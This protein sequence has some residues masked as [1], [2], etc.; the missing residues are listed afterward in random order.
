MKMKS[1]VMSSNKL[2]EDQNAMQSYY[3]VDTLAPSAILEH[4]DSIMTQ[5]TLSDGAS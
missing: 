5:H 4:K 2:S 1:A 3:G